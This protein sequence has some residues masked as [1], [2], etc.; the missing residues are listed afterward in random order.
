MSKKVKN[1]LRF[2]V[3]AYLRSKDSETAKAGT[4]YY[5]GKGQGNRAWS[6]HRKNNIK[7]KDNRYIVFLE[8]N[9][10]D[11]GACALERRYILWYGRKDIGTGILLN[12]TDGGDGMSGMVTVKDINDKAYRVSV[13]DPRYISGELKFIHT[14]TT[15]VKDID[16]NKQRV[17]CDDPRYISGELTSIHIGNS[18]NVGFAIVRNIL[19]DEII[20]MNIHDP[21]YNN[22][23]Y[24]SISKNKVGI[25]DKNGDKFRVSVDDPRY[26]SGELISHSIDKIPVKDKDGNTMSIDRYDPR[27]ISGELISVNTGSAHYKIVSSGQTI[28][29][30]TD[31]PR[32]LTKEI[33]G[34]NHQLVIVKDNDGNKFQVPIDDPRY[35]SGELVGH[36]KG[37]AMYKSKLSGESMYLSKYDPRV[38]SKEFIGISTGISMG[39]NMRNIETGIVEK[40]KKDDPRF[41]SGQYINANVGKSYKK[42]E[43]L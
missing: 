20:R 32:I 6:R 39:S 37:Y 26:I 24:E 9:L 34:L 16:N 18:V 33:V 25:I 17:K 5:I 38:I 14:G 15:L 31:D 10:S 35:I 1:P 2:Y 7:P 8:T 42:K 13:D 22:Y 11:C 12:L 19:T 3:Y 28:T 23:Q 29:T 4:P 30:T 40:I 41:Y 36:T 43:K 21:R 27:Y